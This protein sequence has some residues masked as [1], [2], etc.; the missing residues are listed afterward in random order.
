MSEE[1][2]KSRLEAVIATWLQ[3]LIREVKSQVE[4]E[5]EDCGELGEFREC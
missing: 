1:E 3:S 2:L 5:R 4:R